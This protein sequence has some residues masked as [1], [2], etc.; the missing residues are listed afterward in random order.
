MK[1]QSKSCALE[2]LELRDREC[3]SAMCQHD[4]AYHA[5]DTACGV[6]LP[7]WWTVKISSE[8]LNGSFL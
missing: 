4:E 2:L 7:A 8:L 6:A 1:W 5:T 3:G